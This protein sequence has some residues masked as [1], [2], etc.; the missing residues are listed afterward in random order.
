MTT[1]ALCAECLAR[2]TELHAAG[3]VTVSA[4]QV[5]HHRP[6]M[7]LGAAWAGLEALWEAGVL[8]NG[9]A[10][11]RTFHLPR[12]AGEAAA[13]PALPAPAKWRVFH[14]GCDP[15]PDA[16]S[17][18]FDVERCRTEAHLLH[19]TAHVMRKPWC[20]STDWH[21]FIETRGKQG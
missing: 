21:H 17:Y 12:R 4:F 19:W 7:T 11:M 13:G 15:D 14:R 18:W 9:S 6:G 8:E 3:R 1:P 16:G 5:A 10:D 20:R 2:V